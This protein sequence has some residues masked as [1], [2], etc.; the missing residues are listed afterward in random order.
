MTTTLAVLGL[1][2]LLVAPTP[3]S[4]RDRVRALQGRGRLGGGVR[5]RR[6]TVPGWPV[7]GWR[8]LAGFA[9]LVVAVVAVWIAVVVGP[10]LGLAAA[11]VLGTG[12]GLLAAA[13]RTQRTEAE[14]QGLVTAVRGMVADLEAG[15][16]PAAVLNGAACVSHAAAFASAAQV[17]AAGDDVAAQLAEQARI[18]PALAGLVHVWRVSDDTGAPL[19][20]VL[21][22]LADDLA[23]GAEQRRAVAVALAGPRSS[24]VLLAG[25]PVLGIGLGAA[26]GANPLA[27]LLGTR[28]GQLLM[29]A[30]LALDV[31]GVLWTGQLIR[32]AQRC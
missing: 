24:A 2:G 29:C 11:V 1:F 9:G 28:A 7:S 27:L 19:A 31:A 18:H 6:S 3:G 5:R 20:D 17:A 25:L 15:A 10:L 32:R 12:F 16:R 21:A 22:R 8:G 14:R 23:A 30:G 26:M 4:G 13:R